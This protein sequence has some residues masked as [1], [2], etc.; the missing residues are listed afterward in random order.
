MVGSWQ[1]LETDDVNT[2]VS[3]EYTPYRRQ[4]RDQNH[5]LGSL[6]QS[7]LENVFDKIQLGGDGISRMGTGIHVN[8]VQI[9]P[10][11]YKK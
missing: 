5:I 7:N 9:K 3:A 4:E 1:L 10:K 11:I 2:V 6:L 8:L